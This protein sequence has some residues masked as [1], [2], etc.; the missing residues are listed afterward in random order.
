MGSNYV[1][2]MCDKFVEE[3][4][5]LKNFAYELPTVMMVLSGLKIHQ[6]NVLTQLGS[7]LLF[8]CNK[9]QFYP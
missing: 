5:W 9:T 7:W 2:A 6:E 8:P 1:E 4:R 3:D